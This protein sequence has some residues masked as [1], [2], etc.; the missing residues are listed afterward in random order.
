[1]WDAKRI[2]VLFLVIQCVVILGV[3]LL[4]KNLVIVRQAF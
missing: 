4:E 3:R 1:M 2:F